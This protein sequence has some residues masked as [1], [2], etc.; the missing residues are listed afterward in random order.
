MW[1][2][3]PIV[4]LELGQAFRS[5]RDYSEAFS[6]LMGWGISRKHLSQAERAEALGGPAVLP[7]RICVI[8]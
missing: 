3:W 1:H 2:Q 7:L 6:I 4:T 5:H 8:A